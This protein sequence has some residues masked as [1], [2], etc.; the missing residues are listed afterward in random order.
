MLTQ[1]FHA[2]KLE[3]QRP[4][5]FA[6]K[7][8]NEGLYGTATILKIISDKHNVYPHLATKFLDISYEQ[9]DFDA[10][11]CLRA[12][13]LGRAGVR[14]RVHQLLAVVARA[15]PQGKA[16]LY[17]QRLLKSAQGNIRKEQAC[18]DQAASN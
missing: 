3:S 11:S 17:R 13:L 8:L 7:I 16:P 6:Y 10:A 14:P 2:A 1:I 12:A 4:L 18:F 5:P 15:D 9:A